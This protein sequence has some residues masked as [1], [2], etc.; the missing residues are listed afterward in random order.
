MSRIVHILDRVKLHSASLES[1]PSVFNI[2]ANQRFDE[3]YHLAA[4]SFVAES[5]ADGFSTL[6]TN[7]NGTHY[8]SRVASRA[9]ATMQVLFCRFHEMFGKVHEVPQTENTS[10][11]PRSPLWH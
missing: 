11:Y 7:I 6:N 10:F 3:C 4:Q 2:F 5:F 9:A 1:Y 8:V